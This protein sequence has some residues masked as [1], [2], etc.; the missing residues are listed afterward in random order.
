M[1]A[2]GRRKD[3]QRKKN[4][5]NKNQPKS[6]VPPLK[7]LK[8]V[9]VPLAPAKNLEVRKLASAS[10]EEPD[11]PKKKRNIGKENLED[12]RVI[13]ESFFDLF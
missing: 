2:Q 1:I 5:K 8:R 3:N 11:S 4:A 10:K 13:A 9:P 6:S 12:R 7:K